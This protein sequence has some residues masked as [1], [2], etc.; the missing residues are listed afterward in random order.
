M[1]R[2][3]LLLA[4]WFGCGYWPWGPGT[5]GSIAAVLIA[6]LIHFYLGSS[7]RIALVILIAVFLLPGIWASTRTARLLK[8]KDP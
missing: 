1:N 4:T 8:R 3:A 7:G 2:F 6:A 5:A